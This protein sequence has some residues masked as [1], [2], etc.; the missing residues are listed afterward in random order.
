MHLRSLEVELDVRPS[1]QTARFGVK[2]K[3]AL[4]LASQK[5]SRALRLDRTPERIANRHGLPTL[6]HNAD[7]PPCCAKG[8]NGQRESIL[9]NGI[10]VGKMSLT[11]LLT[12]AGFVQPDQLYRVR[13]GKI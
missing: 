10:Q 12:S 1:Q 4:T 5:G 7:H 3:G 9:R 2:V 8:R 13:I 6:G 11:D